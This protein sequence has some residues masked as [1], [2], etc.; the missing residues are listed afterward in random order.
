M[1]LH[2][3]N[4]DLLELIRARR[5]SHPARYGRQ[6]VKPA[7]SDEQRSRLH[8][9]LREIPEDALGF[10]NFL[11]LAYDLDA[12]GYGADLMAQSTYR[13]TAEGVDEAYDVGLT[14]AGMLR[15]A[16]RTGLC[17]PSE[18]IC[19]KQVHQS[20]IFAT[21]T[22]MV[23]MDPTDPTWCPVRATAHYRDTAV[24]DDD[25]VQLPAWWGYATAM[26]ILVDA[27]RAR[28]VRAA[29]TPLLDDI[30][31]PPAQV[32]WW[33]SPTEHSTVAEAHAARASRWQRA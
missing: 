9:H 4:P 14:G 27:A 33:L 18:E 11:A 29:M 5:A 20:D 12:L 8:A 2:E 3:P 13:R 19:A 23:R 1:G 17:L 30:P 15:L 16:I 28:A 24:Y 31:C 22:V 26:E 25:G 6:G 21:V 10:L 7:S 32:R